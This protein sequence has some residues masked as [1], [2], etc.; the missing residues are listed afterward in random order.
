[1]DAYDPALAP[2]AF[3]LNN[4]GVICYFNGLLQTLAGCTSVTRAVLTNADYMR[5]TDV[6]AALYEFFSAL[7]VMG[8]GGVVARH[9][10]ATN[11][12]C[13]SAR[14][15]SA[16]AAAVKIRRQRTNFGRGQE[17]ASEALVLLLDMLSPHNPD[18]PLG[19]LEAGGVTDNPITNLFLHRFLCITR[20]RKCGKDVS[21]M[22]DH[23]INFNLFHF[24]TLPRYPSTPDSFSRALRLSVEL[25]EDFKCTNC[26]EGGQAGG[27]GGQAG[28]EPGKDDEPKQAFRIY[29]LSM[30]P[31]ILFCAFNQYVGYGGAR[32]SRYFPELLEIPALD[33]GALLFR[34]VGQIEHAGGLHG[35]H[36]WARGLRAGGHVR[37]LNDSAHEPA[38]FS[39]TLGT[40]IIAYHYA[41][42][43]PPPA[44]L[45][46]VTEALSR[47][48]AT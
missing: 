21:E 45:G 24:D 39:P 41:G 35:G 23:A 28:A 42:Y 48:S 14:V 11:I 4:T 7:A 33:G 13:L 3:G 15:C 47:L 18:D 44:A 6:G 17:S 22:T 34:L 10:P 46:E 38:T 37:L 8:P 20:C 19:K 31:E 32:R 26:G 30:V 29:R 25:A 9:P 36:Y 12:A 5:R 16:L 1:M 2:E 27:E 40:Y 43:R